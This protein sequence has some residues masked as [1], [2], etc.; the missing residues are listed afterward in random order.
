M[1]ERTIFAGF[2]GQGVMLMGQLLTSAGMAEGKHVSWLPSYG[3]EMR[4]G[5]ANCSVMVCEEPIGSPIVSKNATS[6]VVMNQPSLFKFEV[7][8]EEGGVCLLNS[9]L[10]SARPERD[11]IKVHC[12]PGN[13]IAAELGNPRV[14]NIVMLG[15]LVE[16]T[17]AVTKESILNALA[18]RLGPTRAHLMEINEQAFDRGAEA[19]RA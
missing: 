16:L 11:D 13:E 5:T 17:G 9:S 15:A 10:V 18:D 8:L 7:D 2:G 12:V 1:A 6:I 3:P 14:T 19:V 4:G